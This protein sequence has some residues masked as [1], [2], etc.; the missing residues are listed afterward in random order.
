MEK[1]S[2]MWVLIDNYDS[3]TY[4]LHH[5]LL[6]LH[7]DIRVLRNDECTLAELIALQ[8]SR[9]IISP[10]PRR[11]EQA[12]ITNVLI[13]HFIGKIPLL[14][15]CLGH[16]A[17]GIRLGAQLVRAR[18][19]MHGKVSQ[20]SHTGAALFDGIPEKFPVM[21]YHSLVLEDWG[22]TG[23]VPLAFTENRELMAF[24][25]AG[26]M[27]TGIQFHPESILTPHG[28]Q[29]LRNWHELCNRIVS[30]FESN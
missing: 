23:L 5:Y 29:I 16:Q 17:L 20:V 30:T 3:F 12:G 8:P 15:I 14:G 11:P 28:A 27:V 1:S 18:Q 25:S 13:D 4:M 19:P 26:G 22:H 6:Q 10:G 24:E 21:R 2:Q 9:I 7:D